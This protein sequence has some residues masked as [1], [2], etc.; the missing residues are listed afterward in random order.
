[1]DLNEFKALL[2]EIDK[3]TQIAHQDYSNK[4]AVHK[5]ALQIMQF[6]KELYYGDLVQSRHIQRIKEII[7]VNVEDII[8]ENNKT[9]D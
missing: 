3:D 1:M 5:A 6:E 7:D 9:R 2:K 8:N 4:S